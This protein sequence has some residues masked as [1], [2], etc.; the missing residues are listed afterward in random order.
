VERQL[1]EPEGG[2]QQGE[3]GHGV[4]LNSQY[5]NDNGDHRQKYQGGEEAAPFRGGFAVF[6][7]LLR[8]LN[9]SPAGWT[10][11]YFHGCAFL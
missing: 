9:A 4:N 1:V 5:S 8:V 7:V 6:T 10:G 3:G 2:D 11:V